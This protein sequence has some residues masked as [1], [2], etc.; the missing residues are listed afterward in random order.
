VRE[1]G[2][3]QGLIE[4]NVYYVSKGVIDKYRAAHGK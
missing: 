2:K 4:K 1:W 3:E